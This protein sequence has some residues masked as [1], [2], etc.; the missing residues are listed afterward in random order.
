M[1]EMGQWATVGIFLA[2]AVL[3]VRDL[4]Q[5]PNAQKTVKDIPAPKLSKFTGPT[6]RFLFW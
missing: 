5:N 4:T 1:A 2:L 3:S 6:L